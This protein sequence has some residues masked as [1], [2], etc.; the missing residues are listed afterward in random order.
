MLESC[1]DY[2]TLESGL[3]SL[4]ETLDETYRRTIL[5]IPAKHK[6]YTTILL[7]LITFSERPLM[8]E[9]AVDAIAVRTDKESSFSPK[10]RMPDPREISRYC[11][12][13]VTVVSIKKDSHDEI[14]TGSKSKTRVELQLAHF[15]GQEYLQ[16]S[17]L[18]SDIA[19]NFQE[20]H[21]GATIA[22]VC[23]SSLLQFTEK[24]PS[25][26]IVQ[27]FP[28]VDYAARY[29]IINAARAQDTDNRML[30]LI[31]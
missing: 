7:Q 15:S 31:E 26:E 1:L 5:A 19:L 25:E 21:G 22:K 14:E 2:S 16:S 20:C 23:L 29:W 11:S 18:D 6:R 3:D 24:V 27:H 28:F 4:P 30:Q 13:L 9:E 17:R 8:I 10:Y 12:S